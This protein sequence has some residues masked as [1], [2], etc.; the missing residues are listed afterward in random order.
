MRDRGTGSGWRGVALIVVVYVYFLIFAEFAFLTRLSELGIGGNGLK[1]VM[2]AMAAGGILLSLLTPRVRIFPNP[3]TRL[4]VGLAFCSTAALLTLLPLGITAGAIVAFL[5]GTALGITT[6][7]LVTHLRGWTGERWGIVYAGVGTGLAY[8]ICNVPAVFTATPQAQAIFAAGL[9]GIATLF[10]L[11]SEE[12]SP[13]SDGPRAQMSFP[14]ALASFAAL[15]WLDSAAFY[16]IQHTATLKAGTWLGSA[17]LWIN[18]GLHLCAAVI[19]ALLL[20]RGRAATS[21]ALAFGALAFACV[22]LR[23]PSLILSASLFYPAG[24]SVYSVA[25]VAYP[26]FLAGSESAADRGRKAGWIYALAGWIGSALGIGMG[27]NLGHVP[28]AFVAIAGVVVL[29]PSGVAIWKCRTRELAF[30]AGIGVIA[31]AVYMVLPKKQSFATRTDVERGRQIYISEGCIHCHSQYVRPDSPDVLMWGPTES[32]EEIHAQRPPLIGNRRQGPDL[33]QVGFR[34]S[35]LWLKAHLIN[36]SE[37][38]YRSPMPSF[39][40]LFSDARG[41]DLVAYL[42]SRRGSD[43]QQQL[44]R[45]AA[46][47]PAQAALTEANGR[48][49]GLDYERHCATCHDSSGATRL[50]WLRSWRNIPQTLTELREYANREP[51]SKLARIA[52]FGMPGTDMPGFE[53]LSDQ[54]IASIVFWLRFAPME[55]TSQ[56]SPH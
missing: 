5:I 6:V 56:P 23:S 34:R 32:M 53:Y 10:P 43:E 48:N 2:A 26:S 4:R 47:S 3:A 31:F 45:E 52:K 24:V 28:L 13:A 55:A 12:P 27:Q 19:A 17:H 37:I 39:A 40:F 38:S 8:L 22:L 33:S 20:R 41:G 21:L 36:P 49:G 25:L 7:T 46:W 14:V 50:R 15:I 42:S 9:C 29:S 44:Q 1:V 35:P 51:Q 30:V 54:Q 11:D 18:G 16:I